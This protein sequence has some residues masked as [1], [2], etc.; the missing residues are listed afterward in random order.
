LYDKNKWNLVGGKVVA[1]TP[2]STTPTAPKPATPTPQTNYV[3][4]LFFSQLADAKLRMG[5]QIAPLSA[6]LARYSQGWTQNAD[7]T[8]A[9]DNDDAT[10]S[11]YEVYSRDAN[12]SLNQ[13]RYAMNANLASRGFG[14]SGT[15]S[16]KTDDWENRRART[17][18]DLDNEFG[19]NKLFQVNRGMLDAENRYKMYEAD[20]RKAALERA[21]EAGGSP[22]VPGASKPKPSKPSGGARPVA[23]KKPGSGGGKGA[24]FTHGGKTYAKSVWKLV[25]GKVVKR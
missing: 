6:D 3:D 23:G 11:L 2:G 7:G 10:T 18:F 15:R 21:R 5:E 19:T 17:M 9:L 22:V 25:N 24:Y 14:R 1:K 12:R 4:S 16:V 13:D 8:W 20:L